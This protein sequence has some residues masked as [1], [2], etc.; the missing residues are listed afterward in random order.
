MPQVRRLA[1][2]EQRLVPAACLA[3]RLGLPP[4]HAGFPSAQEPLP[5]LRSLGRSEAALEA[6]FLRLEGKEQTALFPWI[7]PGL[8]NR[9]SKSNLRKP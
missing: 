1:S 9:S 5:G 6:Y 3:R 8:P 7:W 4:Q 2:S